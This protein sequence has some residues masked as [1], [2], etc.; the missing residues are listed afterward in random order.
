MSIGLSVTKFNKAWSNSTKPTMCKGTQD[1]N[2]SDFNIDV[3]HEHAVQT[4][5]FAMSKNKIVIMK[6]FPTYFKEL[7]S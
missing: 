3:S 4:L 7:M 2:N 6:L 1:K 5:I